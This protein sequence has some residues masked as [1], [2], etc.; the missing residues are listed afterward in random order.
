MDS[1]SREHLIRHAHYGDVPV[2]Q[3]LARTTWL[4]TYPG[5]ISQEQI[6]YMLN[7]MYSPATILSELTNQT[8]HWLVAEQSGQ[9][10]GYASY[11]PF[12]ADST[13]ARLHK[14]YVLPRVK[15]TGLGKALLA[16]VER[17]VLAMGRTVLE[18]N[19][20]KRNP[21]HQFYVRQGFEL[22]REEVLDIGSGFV[23]DD[24]VMRKKLATALVPPQASEKTA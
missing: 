11:G 1:E 3:Q 12:K 7:R 2:L 13:V 8:A 24:F 20:N 17:R 23:M 14:L 19:V 16:A 4:A 6:D 5:I 21:S 10:V 22:F 15:G 9:A 18:L